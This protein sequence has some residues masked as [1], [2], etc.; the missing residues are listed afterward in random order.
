MAE[1]RE[2]FKERLRVDLGTVLDA[3]SFERRGDICGVCP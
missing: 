2:S 1:D 3:E